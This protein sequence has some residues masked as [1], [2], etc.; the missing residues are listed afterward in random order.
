MV[1]MTFRNRILVVIAAASL[2]AVLGYWR[3]MEE[4]S[5]EAVAENDGPPNRQTRERR[6]EVR[7]DPM[8]RLEGLRGRWVS[9]AVKM[10]S[11]AIIRGFTVSQIKEALEDVRPNGMTSAEIEQVKMLFY[12][13][14]QIDPVAA[15][16]A[17]AAPPHESHSAAIAALAAWMKDDPD[18][19][20]HW[21]EAQPQRHLYHHGM[22]AKHLASGDRRRALES[23]ASYE[24]EMSRHVITELARRVGGSAEDRAEFLDLIANHDPGL[25]AA[26]KEA[27]VSS[28]SE[29]EPE[30]ALDEIAGAISDPVAADQARGQIL[31]SWSH[32]DPAEALAW[33]KVNPNPLSI[34]ARVRIY[35]QW[36]MRAPEAALEGFASL[37]EEPGFGEAALN[38]L[39]VEHL[40]SKPLEDAGQPPNFRGRQLHPWFQAWNAANPGSAAAWMDSLDHSLR[41][42]FQP[43][44]E[45]ETH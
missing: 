40:R 28:R 13:W 41:L 23:A 17:A 35:G 9:H 24:E 3:G 18:A 45:H 43:Q 27:L 34:R 20:F 5:G 30:A 25:L 36:T 44:P 6:G 12:R 10:E 8:N 31:I 14:A 7:Q 37:A 11:W 16:E 15:L 33:M 22:M 21:A 2:A 19:A 32:E 29:H 39:L 4:A 26:A 38:Q 42:G 1:R